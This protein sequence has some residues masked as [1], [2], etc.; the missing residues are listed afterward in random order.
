MRVKWST[1]QC[2]KEQKS[3]SSQGQALSSVVPPFGSHQS[4]HRLQETKGRQSRLNR[5]SPDLARSLLPAPSR[6]R[7]LDLG[8]ALGF[9]VEA[10]METCGLWHSGRSAWPRVGAALGVP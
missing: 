2:S 7:N 6:Q 9:M 8:G 10:H 5:D 3:L 1:G 4:S